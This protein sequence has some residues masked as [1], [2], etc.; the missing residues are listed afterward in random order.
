MPTNVERGGTES[1]AATF[2]IQRLR[3]CS[4]MH[5]RGVP[6]VENRYCDCCH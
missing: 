1:I 5:E 4:L 3:V 6:D 2:L